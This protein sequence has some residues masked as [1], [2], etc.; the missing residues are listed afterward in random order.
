[1]NI[2]IPTSVQF[3]GDGHKYS[4]PKPLCFTHAV[5]RAMKGERVDVELE[6]S[7]DRTVWCID[8]EEGED[9]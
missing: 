4:D 9:L 8:C 3:T 7:E 1:M 5:Q 2:S 6:M